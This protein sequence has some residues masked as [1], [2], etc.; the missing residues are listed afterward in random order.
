MLAEKNPLSC[1]ILWKG[2]VQVVRSELDFKLITQEGQVGFFDTKCYNSKHFT[3]SE[4]S[5]DQIKRADDYNYWN[6]PAGFVVWFIPLF[7]VVFFSGH[8]I[9]KAGPGSR[10]TSDQGVRLGRFENFNIGAIMERRPH[11]QPLSNRP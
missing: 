10:F 2:R 9:T 11:A 8:Q 5:A 4:L 6:V 3:Y 7:E 1:R